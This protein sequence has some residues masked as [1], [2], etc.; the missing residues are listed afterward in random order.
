MSTYV[1]VV[2][3]FEWRQMQEFGVRA[4]SGMQTFLQGIPRL[5]SWLVTLSI[6]E[7]AG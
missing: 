6:F 2:D 7:C 5:T 4:N 3:A 1:I